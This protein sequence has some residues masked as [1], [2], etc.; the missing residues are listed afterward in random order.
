MIPP[1]FD[2]TA[3]DSLEDAIRLLADEEGEAKLIAGGHSLLPLMKLRLAAPTSLV[4]L[5]RVP[6]LRGI[7]RRDGEY[8]IGA[9]T[10]H[11]ELAS[12]PELG[13]AAHAAALIA[14]QQ[15]R[16][17]GTIG[18]S[19]AH[20]DPASDLPAVLAASGGAVVVRGPQGKR[21]I[22]AEDFFLEYLTTALELGEVITHVRLPA[23]DGYGF[24]Y[25]K[26][27]RRAED[28]AIVGVCA[29]VAARNGV[30]EDVRVG[31]VNMGSTPLVAHR[32]E[33]ELLHGP[34]NADAIRRAAA[35]AADGAEPPAELNAS[36]DYKRHLARVLTRRA[37]DGAAQGATPDPVLVERS[38]RERRQL[39]ERKEA[40]SNGSRPRS[41]ESGTKI[42]QSFEVAAP[43][44]HVWPG[45]VDVEEVAPCLP[46][47]EV[48]EVAPGSYNG[49]FRVKI[50]PTTA[51]YHGRLEFESVDDATRTLVMRASGQDTRGGGSATAQLVVH[52]AEVEN[53]TRV[54]VETNYTITGK[55]ARFGR[56]GMIEDVANVLMTEFAACL[57]RRLGTDGT[58]EADHARPL[59]G[60]SLVRS[61]ITRRAKRV[62]SR[63]LGR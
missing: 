27:A 38:K 40:P 17:R 13:L 46:G 18:G 5:R 11:S 20:G 36:P 57:E 39:G 45:L 31:L 10:R 30:C 6:G 4:D 58:A 32:V 49:T 16:N 2:Y 23:F 37:L 52:L 43:P 21:E 24:H 62:L 14:D 3:P 50:G 41:G 33:E 54:D 8:L 34:L 35:Y 44:D 12:T 19:L 47:A 15:V 59:H 48:T 55:L 26:F 53:G 9:L 22:A 56:S 28:W 51:A 61:V 1:E 63:V 7:E 42:T 60:A 29:L 25:E